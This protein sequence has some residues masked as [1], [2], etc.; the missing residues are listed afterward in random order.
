MKDIGN[1]LAIKLVWVVLLLSSCSYKN[2]DV[3]FYVA[4]YNM[5]LYDAGS[6]YTSRIID[7]IEIQSDSLI[8]N[9]HTFDLYPSVNSSHKKVMRFKKTINSLYCGEEQL[10]LS[11]SLKDSTI[12][13]NGTSEGPSCGL[14]AI[15]HK[16]KG[17]ELIGGNKYYVFDKWKGEYMISDTEG[18]I[19]SEVL[20][21]ENF[22]LY[23]EYS[24]DSLSFD[25]KRKLIIRTSLEE[26]FLEHRQ[27]SLG[28][29]NRY[30]F[31]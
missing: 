19:L 4:K 30:V 5:T 1:L 15:R 26:I 6:E 22:I 13:W 27:K 24:K 9:S 12:R 28:K 17:C 11:T 31:P 7:T 16:Y 8:I 20:Y 21:D 10:Y 29:L 14:F 18:I 23:K 2:D 3:K 25:Y